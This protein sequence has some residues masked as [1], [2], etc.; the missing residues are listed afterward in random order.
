MASTPALLLLVLLMLFANETTAETN[1][2]HLIPIGSTIS[3][4]GKN[5]SWSSRSGLFAFGFYPHGNSYAVGIWLLTQP[6][7]T[8]VWTY[9]P[10]SPSMSSNSTLRLTKEDGLLLLQ[11]NEDPEFLIPLYFLHQAKVEVASA[12]MLDSGNFVLYDKN[13]SMLWSSFGD[14]SDT[15]LGGQNLTGGMGLV[16]SVSQSDHSSGHFLL[17]RQ[18]DEHLAACRV[19]STCEPEDAYWAKNTYFEGY[20]YL[21]LSL[22]I[23]G[24]LCLKDYSSGSELECLASSKNLTDK[25]KN[26]TF[27]YRATLDEDGDFRLYAHQFEGNTSSGVQTL[28]KAVEGDKCQVPLCGL[29]S[30]CFIKSDKVMCQCYPGFIPIKSGGNDTRFL[31]CEQNHS[32]DNCESIEDPTM[33]Y[34]MTSLKD[35]YWGGSP[36][37]VVPIEMETCKKSCR[38][39]CDCRAVLY[40]S[41]ICEKYK[42]PLL[43]GRSSKDASMTAFVKMP[44]GIVLSPTSNQTALSPTKPCVFVDDKRSLIMILSLTLGWI[45]FFGL[46][47]V[48]YIFIIYRHQVHSWVYKCYAAGQLNKLVADDEGEDVD[49]KILERMVKLGLWCVQDKPSLRPTMKDVI[50]MLEGLKDIP[51]PPSPAFFV[52]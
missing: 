10:Y 39:D 44:S 41:G 50:L 46:V 6:K 23:E 24:S 30:Y 31:D 28:W 37:L 18:L 32:K 22:S 48:L 20:G 9:H 7:H 35:I 33:M 47:F 19:N 14:P 12:S 2:T 15:I 45:S 16:S 34:N 21:Q 25:S 52:E 1:H 8:I 29:N 51:V 26:A 13:F 11:E 3:P 27:I 17:S 5:T 40:K 49:W 38:K 36:Y 43:Y 4:T 42:L